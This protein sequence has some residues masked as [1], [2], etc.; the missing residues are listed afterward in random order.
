MTKAEQKLIDGDDFRKALNASFRSLARR[1][2]SRQEIEKK[3][4]EKGFATDT[5]KSVIDK[6]LSSKYLD[7]KV[8]AQRLAILKT[9]AYCWSNIKIE[10]SLKQ[11]GIAPEIIR[12]SL[13]KARDE[14]SEDDAIKAIIVR[15]LKDRTLTELDR[16]DVL[17][18][19]R[20]LAAKGFSF[21]AIKRNT[22]IPA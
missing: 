21:S 6:L 13:Q 20:S 14:I 17:K 18:L 11:K 4:T 15:K 12:D 3:L 1:P 22:T 5:V 8:F 9:S 10:Q 2:H 16:N 7:D 19:M